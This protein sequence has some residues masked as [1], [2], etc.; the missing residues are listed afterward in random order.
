MNPLAKIMV[1]YYKDEQIANFKVW[2]K[3][4]FE[5]WNVKFN[6]NISLLEYDLLKKMR[7]DGVMNRH[8]C[9]G[10]MSHSAYGKLAMSPDYVRAQIQ[11]GFDNDVD[12]IYNCI[13]QSRQARSEEVSNKKIKTWP[14][15]MITVC[16]MNPSK[17]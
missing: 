4:I 13:N 6:M 10:L 16:K 5:P 15:F 3:D 12:A 14:I 17:R 9:T 2:P 1:T 8:K 11:D 7:N